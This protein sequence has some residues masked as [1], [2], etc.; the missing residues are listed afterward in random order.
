MS[1]AIFNYFIIMPRQNNISKANVSRCNMTGWHIFHFHHQNSRYSTAA[2]RAV[3]KN[4][5]ATKKTNFFDF[6]FMKVNELYE[7]IEHLLRMHNLSVLYFKSRI[8]IANVR[9][10]LLLGIVRKGV[11]VIHF[12][13][14]GFI[15]YGANC[16]RLNSAVESVTLPPF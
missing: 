3:M 9:D 13:C 10:T 5:T 12:G 11:K 15:L 1:V 4:R 14:S 8:L 2:R 6:I 7:S 16:L